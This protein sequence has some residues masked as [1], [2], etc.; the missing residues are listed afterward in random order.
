MP[1]PD[2][3]FL[4]PASVVAASQAPER[5]LQPAGAAGEWARLAAMA[6]AGSDPR[7][8]E[9]GDL[10]ITM[11]NAAAARLYGYSAAEAIGQPL[12]MLTPPGDASAWASLVRRVLAGEEIEAHDTVHRA[13]DGRLIA[14]SLTIVPFQDTAGSVVGLLAMTRPNAFSQQGVAELA[15]S[16]RRFRLA[17]D[18]TPSLAAL[19]GLDGCLLQVNRA[20]CA[21]LGYTEAEL[22]S[23]P[24]LRIV[25][26]GDIRYGRTTLLETLDGVEAGGGRKI[27]LLH[28]DGHQIWVMFRLSIARNEAGEPEYF[29]C[30]AHDLTPE[31]V[32]QEQ[33][34]AAHQQMQEFQERVGG[35]FIELDHDW[36][37]V[38]INAAAGEL[39]GGSRDQLQGQRWEAVADP[40]LQAPMQDAISDAITRRQ[41][42]FVAE[43]SY[44]AHEAW[45]TLRVYPST[46]G[47]SLFL[48]DITTLRDLEHELRVAEMRFQALIEQLPAT[49]YLHANDA[50][51]TMLYVSPYFEKMAGY[52]MANGLPFADVAH[53]LGLIHPV[54]RPRIIN[55]M[56]AHIGGRGKV[57]LHYRLR[58]EHGDY[59]WVSDIY[60]PMVD[61]A[62]HVVAWQGVMIDITTRVLAETMMARLAS[63]VENADDAIYSRTLDGEITSWNGGAERLYGYTAQEAIGR[64]IFDLFPGMHPPTIGTAENL[65]AHGSIQFETQHHHRDGH[66]LEVAVALG[67]VRDADGVIVGVSGIVRDISER[68]AADRELRAALDAARAGERAKGL[69]LAM[70]SHELRTPLQAVLGYSDFLLGGRPGNLSAEQL[71]DIGYIHQGASR[72]VHLIDQMLDLSRMEA[73]RLDLKR[74]AVDLLRVL[75]AVRQDIAPQAEAKGLALTVAAPGRLPRVLGDAERVRQI[76]LNL[77]GNAVKFTETGEITI[78]ARKRQGWVDVAVADTGIGIAAE[79]V[80]TIFEEFRQ[81]DTRLSRRHGG[82][83]L[84]LAI[85]RRLAQQMGGEIA[86]VSE[87]GAGST[88]TLRLPMA[89]LIPTT[90]PARGA[91]TGGV[92]LRHGG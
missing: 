87:L 31:M 57:E 58:C 82:A 15:A 9:S 79:D 62:G 23:T 18:D 74:E 68:I 35:V 89:P 4:S 29:I 44:P 28:K 34:R 65:D 40:A 70:M 47:A 17:F 1:E 54:D 33:L 83:G 90:A 85:A 67:P 84:G 75:E 52:S 50:D 26:P 21:L 92:G 11:W 73:G 69:F 86:V 51:E 3:G 41:R 5:T 14:V 10:V 53:W 81:V 12:A 66:I 45:Y 76:V 48:R 25:Y 46:S 72:M 80:G 38:E 2:P 32:A 22:L 42:A 19:L 60:A 77:A 43:L 71:E 13:S 49:V 24:M 61:D 78:T 36:R 6:P 39:L 63:I 64:T 30:Q 8:G 7:T 37:I 59:I 56:A 88:F 20:G 91:G 16:E 55:E 27:R